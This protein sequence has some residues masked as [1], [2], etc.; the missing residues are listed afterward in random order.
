V[1]I[2]TYGSTLAA[3]LLVKAAFPVVRVLDPL[4]RMT[5]WQFNR[6]LSV[7]Y[8]P[9]QIAVGAIAGGYYRHK[10]ER[11]YAL[12]VW[13]PPLAYWLDKVATFKVSVLLNP[14]SQ[15]LQH[16]VGNGCRVPECWDQMRYTA[17]LY[18]SFAYTLGFLLEPAVR[19]AAQ[20]LRRT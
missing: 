8:F 19:S 3:A 6:I 7:P 4:Y 9:V 12:W 20:R 17:P 11:S 15:T 13:I 10:T 2:A 1:F 5:F 14:W 18:A 16:F